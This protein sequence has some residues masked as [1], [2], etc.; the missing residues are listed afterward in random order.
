MSL[1]SEQRNRHKETIRFSHKKNAGKDTKMISGQTCEVFRTTEM[2]SCSFIRSEAMRLQ[3]LLQNAI[4][5]RKYF[6]VCRSEF[7]TTFIF[8]NK[9]H[10]VQ[11]F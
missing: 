11:Y 1:V 9:E 6:Y 8:R 10:N 5:L 7:K 4:F 2:V 3:Q